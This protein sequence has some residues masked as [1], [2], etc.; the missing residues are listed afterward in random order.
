MNQRTKL[1]SLAL[2]SVLLIFS[3]SVG[4]QKV[5]AA[6]TCNIDPSGGTVVIN[7]PTIFT[8]TAANA[9]A[10]Y[11]VMLDSVLQF[12][13]TSDGTGTATFSLTISTVGSHI[14]QIRM[15]T[16]GT[17]SIVATSSLLGDDPIADMMPWLLLVISLIIVFGVIGLIID[18]LHFGRR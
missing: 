15:G 14:V 7:T 6:A 2:V 12:T 1:V 16:A 5:S 17:G 18:K 4:A 3:I 10:S 8:I 13:I 9:S 11:S